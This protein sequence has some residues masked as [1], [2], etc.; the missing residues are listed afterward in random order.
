M[1]TYLKRNKT[2]Y[3]MKITDK[4]FSVMQLTENREEYVVL[5]MFYILGFSFSYCFHSFATPFNLLSSAIL[6]K[7]ELEKQEKENQIKRDITIIGVSLSILTLI[8]TLSWN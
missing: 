5:E 1:E 2:K 3:T 7:E 6:R 8:L 4:K